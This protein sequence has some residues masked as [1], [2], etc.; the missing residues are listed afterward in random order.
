M[1]GSGLKYHGV[2]LGGTL[3]SLGQFSLYII[4]L[5]KK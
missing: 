4:Q 3:W 1:Q 2:E 5:D